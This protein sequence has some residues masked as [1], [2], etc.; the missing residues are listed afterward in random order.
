[1]WSEIKRILAGTSNAYQLVNSKKKRGKNKTFIPI[2]QCK[3]NQ[4]Q[5]LSLIC[6]HNRFVQCT[7]TL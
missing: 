2:E 6:L 5:W 3:T 4:M 7:D 1:M